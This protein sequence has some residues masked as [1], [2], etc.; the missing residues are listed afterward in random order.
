MN[1]HKFEF[2]LIQDSYNRYKLNISF[3]LIWFLDIFDAS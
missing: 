3:Y 1:S 2:D